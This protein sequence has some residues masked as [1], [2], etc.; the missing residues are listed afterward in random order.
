MSTDVKGTSAHVIASY[1][2]LTFDLSMVLAHIMVFMI[3]DFFFFLQVFAIV[4]PKIIGG[5]NAPSPVGELGMVEMTQALDL[6]DVCYEQVGGEF[7]IFCCCLV[8]VNFC[9]HNWTL[10]YLCFLSS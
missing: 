9:S 7:W 10:Y 1:I 5:K 8:L 3:Y 2:W 4:A 6:I